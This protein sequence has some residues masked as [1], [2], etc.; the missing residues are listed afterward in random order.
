[1]NIQKI[2]LSHL[3]EI[4]KLKLKKYRDESN[5][6]L[7]E[8]EKILVEA[9]KSDWHLMEVYL[10]RDNFHLI[11]QLKKF[12]SFENCKIFELSDK[13][14]KKISNEITPSGIAAKVE[15]KKFDL[16]SI[17]RRKNKLIPVFERISDPGNL[18]TIIRSA[19]WF[20]FNT[21]GLSKNSV[22]I[23]NPK[24]IR[25]SM[26][27]IFH[28]QILD[29]ID[30]KIFIDQMRKN[31]YKIVGTITTGKSVSKFN[32]KENCLLIFGNESMGISK[33]ILNLCDEFITIPAFGSAE[34]LNLAISASIFFYEL[35]RNG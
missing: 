13:E 12:P 30:L 22:E 34:S 21:I 27:S 33:E 15:K 10:T 31:N 28:L 18:G 17:L 26:G 24:V 3:K 23:T 2:S 35:R 5:S 4:A 29:E 20:G 9:L 14:F 7:I 16:N 19:D 32:L 25:A 8:S 1:M 6:F 11:N